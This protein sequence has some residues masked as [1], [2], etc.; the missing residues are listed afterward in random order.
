MFPLVAIAFLV[1]PI[2][3]IYVI[4]QVGQQIGIA[5]TIL[6]LLL[7]GFLGAWLFRREGRR[8]WTAFSSALGAGRYPGRE[9]A[10]GALVLVGGTLLLSPGFVTDVVGLLLLL[11][12]TR[13]VARRIL[14]RL[15]PGRFGLAATF[16]DAHTPEPPTGRAE[17]GQPGSRRADPRVV[18]DGDVIEGD[19][20][21]RDGR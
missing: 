9:V 19:I 5:W 1:V 15:L 4:V 8:T 7:D 11:P 3:E 16:L 10:N 12:P 20:I 17:A 13:A 2:V 18:I 14:L 21:D 6:L